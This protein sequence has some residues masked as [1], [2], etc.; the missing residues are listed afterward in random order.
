[1]VWEV[2][3]VAVFGAQTLKCVISFPT[4]VVSCHLSKRVR[5]DECA[6]IVRMLMEDASVAGGRGSSEDVTEVG[7]NDRGSVWEM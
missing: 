4:C 3:V 1:M 5:A 7:G 6:G 2:E